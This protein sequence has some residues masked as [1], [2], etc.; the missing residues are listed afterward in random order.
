VH[1]SPRYLRSARRLPILPAL[2]TTQ[3]E[4][5]ALP[6]HRE[7]GAEFRCF[8]AGVVSAGPD[9][10]RSALRNRFA[11]DRRCSS[12]G[13]RHQGEGFCWRSRNRWRPCGEGVGN[14]CRRWNDGRQA[15]VDHDPLGPSMVGLKADDG[16]IDVRPV[17]RRGRLRQVPVGQKQQREQHAAYKGEVSTKGHAHHRRYDRTPKGPSCNGKK[18][19]SF[20]RIGHH[21]R[22][23]CS[24]GNWNIRFRRELLTA[25]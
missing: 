12:L 9:H 22:A 10:P 18:R 23:F 20:R 2:L 11:G 1:K 3:G 8:E 14:P 15:G 4:P 16:S 21:P 7:C 6:V 19:Q 25:S 5:C 13:R 17:R 24:G